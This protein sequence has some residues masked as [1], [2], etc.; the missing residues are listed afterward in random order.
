MITQQHAQE[1]LSLAFIHALTAKAGVNLSLGDR[2][3]YGVDGQFRPVQVR[4][5][6]HVNSGFNLDFQLKATTA[7]ELD[8]HTDSIIY[9]LEAKTY[10]D[11]AGR[12][13][14]AEGIVLIVLCLPPN[15]DHWLEANHE[16]LML[17]NCCYWYR[18][19]GELTNNTT[20]KRIY[21]PRANLLT[22]EEVRK[23]L[24][25]EQTRRRSLFVN[26]ASHD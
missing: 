10:N 18:I 26:G 9:D 12:D 20:T 5:G 11:L 13:P 14:E 8:T 4:D 15:T 7:W 24:G 23:I 6:R 22:A 17:K 16:F 21:I 2:H 3:D 25:N 19:D 1:A